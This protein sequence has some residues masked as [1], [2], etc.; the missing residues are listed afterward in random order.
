MSIQL[1]APSR[2]DDIRYLLNHH[3]L[4]THQINAFAET[5]PQERKE[6]CLSNLATIAKDQLGYLS[7]LARSE[8]SSEL[9]RRQIDSAVVH[10]LL[11]S[12]EACCPQEQRTCLIDALTNDILRKT[13]YCRPDEFSPWDQAT[14]PPA[15][16]PVNT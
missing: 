4:V 10:L 8:I 11:S 2:Y 13:E 16:K 1:C 14:K 6:R 7:R 15:P 5:L 3:A 12:S 9:L